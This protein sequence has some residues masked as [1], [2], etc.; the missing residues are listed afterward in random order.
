V[1]AAEATVMACPHCGGI[2][3]HDGYPSASMA[4][5][6]LETT[7]GLPKIFN[8]DSYCAILRERAALRRAILALSAGLGRLSGHGATLQTI[9]EVQSLVAALGDEG[10]D[11]TSGLQT[12]RE[13][14]DKMGK[15]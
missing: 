8:L 14:I 3:H 9:S 15:Q 4:S 6:L 1:E 11:R 2:M 13:I 10:A 5:F 7:R 12:I